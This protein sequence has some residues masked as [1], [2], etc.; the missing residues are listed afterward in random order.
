MKKIIRIGV[1]GLLAAGLL[2]AC[3]PAPVQPAESGTLSTV[4][5]TTALPPSTLPTPTGDPVT[6]PGW[7]GRA[8]VELLTK[9]EGERGELTRISRYQHQ[10]LLSFSVPDPQ[11]GG[12]REAYVRGMDLHSGTFSD[13]IPLSQQGDIATWLENGRVLV[14]NALTATAR[15]YDWRGQMQLS[16]RHGTPSVLLSID[17]AGSG[18]LWCY[19]GDSAHLTKVSLESGAVQE[20]SISG[21]T[22]GYI[23]GHR[24]GIT[25]YCGRDGE[26][27][28]YYA[29][30]ISG[31]VT[32]LEVPDEV[33]WGEGVWYTDLHP[34]RIIDPALPQ[35]TYVVSGEDAFSWIAAGEGSHLLTAAYTEDGE[36]TVYS[37]L[38]YMGA[39][40][41]PALTLPVG[42]TWEQTLFAD[43][44][45]L[46]FT[47]SH[48]GEDGRVGYSL[49]R[50]NYLHDGRAADLQILQTVDTDTANAQIAS[51]IYQRWGISVIYTEPQLHQVASDYSTVP[52]TDPLK[53]QNALLQLK[54]ALS[55]YPDGFFEDLCY[56]SYTRLELY[57]CG[58]FKPLTASGISNAEAL[59]NTRGT[60]LV[61][62]FDVGRM[63]GE[64]PRVLAHELLH[65][66]ERRIDQIDVDA[67]A[68]W[69]T[70]TP[71]GH[72]AY[73]YSYYD[74]KGQQVSDRSHTYSYENDPTKAYFVDAYSKSFPTEDRARIFEKLVESGG[75]PPFADSPV[76]MAKAR[77]LC[78]LI[79]D[80][81]PSVAALERASW[82]V[83]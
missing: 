36:E 52:V 7:E 76:L 75:D 79:R 44:N 15:V 61:I 77:T 25:Y 18:V 59:S 71:D 17:P 35:Q 60:V 55:A 13:E 31:D 30:T 23:A 22:G 6:Y 3:T 10:L 80:Y 51:Q 63:D 28:R 40:R 4:E 24:E 45:T 81:F 53:L 46:Y 19:S 64:Y 42:S 70:L 58:K 78:R 49:C 54:E 43:G 56:G 26:S 38:D 65:I 12:Y 68:E 1:I 50:W 16:Y 57:L 66:M 72:D 14:Y 29:I 9:L 67:L 62:G 20:I 37:V 33:F 27:S 2:T 73:Y 48:Y 83:E 11:E 39:L 5:T 21:C 74:E 47:L 34:N 82:E 8:D 41:Y 69:I 32:R